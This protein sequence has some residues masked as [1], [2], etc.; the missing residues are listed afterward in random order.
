MTEIQ[1]NKLWNFLGICL[2]AVFLAGYL[3]F[4]ILNTKL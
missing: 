3:E 1:N 4:V 2:P